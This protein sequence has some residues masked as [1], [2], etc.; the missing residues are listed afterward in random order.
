MSYVFVIDANRKPLNPVHQGYA[1]LL[2]TRKKAAVFRRYPFT[3][4]M[5]N[6]LANL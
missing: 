6:E 4:A 5:R 2:L 3:H 1:R